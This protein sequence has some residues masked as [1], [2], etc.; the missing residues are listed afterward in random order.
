MIIYK[1]NSLL[2]HFKIAILF[3]SFILSF[4]PHIK[5]YSNTLET[6]VSRSLVNNEIICIAKLDSNIKNL[7]KPKAISKILPNLSINNNFSGATKSYSINLNQ[8]V[9]ELGKINLEVESSKIRSSLG[10]IEL[11]QDIEDMVIKVIDAYINLLLS[12][13]IYSLKSK[14]L[15]FIKSYMYEVRS[16][17]KKNNIDQIYLSEMR[18]FLSRAL[19]EEL[20]A[21]KNMRSSEAHFQYV[22]K[23]DPHITLEDLS[24]KKKL[25]WNNFVEFIKEVN[26]QNKDLIKAKKEVENSNIETNLRKK[27]LLPA[28]SANMSVSP[29][30]DKRNFSF[31]VY[32]KIPLFNS[33]KDYIELK[34][35]RYIASKIKYQL[36]ITKREILKKSKELWADHQFFENFLNL[37]FEES[38]KAEENLSKSIS[39]AKQNPEY[40]VEVVR[41]N[42]DLIRLTINQET[43]KKKFLINYYNML[44][45]SG[46]LESEFQYKSTKCFKE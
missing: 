35:A 3:V 29:S 2:K 30:G 24:T 31:M 4:F 1:A 7:S 6:V 19:L 5:S 21:E 36:S 9:S 43:N 37:H 13:K 8:K 14:N 27:N 41:L 26:I 46:N 38:K 10:E 16:L 18:S 22:T 12:R 17:I 15:T 33:G 44:H 25:F 45:I 39:L 40:M 28:V 32:L 42:F 11:N 23:L 34:E 20:E